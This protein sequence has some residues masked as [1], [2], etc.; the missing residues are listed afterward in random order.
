[1]YVRKVFSSLHGYHNSKGTKQG[2][3]CL[4]QPFGWFSIQSLAKLS[5]TLVSPDPLNNVE[6]LAI[7]D[8]KR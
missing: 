8:H 5:Q 3:S 4:H 7:G 1:M 6:K 2:R